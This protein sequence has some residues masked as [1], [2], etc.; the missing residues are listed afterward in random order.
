MKGTVEPASSKATA[1]VTCCGLTASSA[2]RR[3]SMDSMGK[4]VNFSHGGA[5]YAERCRA[6]QDLPN[7]AEPARALRGVAGA[8]R[9]YRRDP[10]SGRVR[11]SLA[12]CGAPDPARGESNFQHERYASGVL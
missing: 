5:H 4:G 9:K 2:A 10:L 7:E 12:P 1:A 6:Q 8:R 11:G 3:D